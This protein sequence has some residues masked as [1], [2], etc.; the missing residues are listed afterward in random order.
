MQRCVILFDSECT[1]AELEC[2]GR[3]EIRLLIELSLPT[4]TSL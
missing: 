2:N 1:V 4:T 3:I